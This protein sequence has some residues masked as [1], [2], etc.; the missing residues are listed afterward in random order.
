MIPMR[1]ARSWTVCATALLLASGASAAR[2]EQVPAQQWEREH[3]CGW[4]LSEEGGVRHLASIGQGDGA[5][6][7]SLSDPAF[8]AWSEEDRPMVELILDGDLQN[9]VEAEG[10]ATHGG[11][12]ASA[13][14]GLYLEPDD[15]AAL[16]R[17]TQLQMRRDGQP[18]VDITLAGNLELADLEACVPP[19]DHDH[20]DE[21]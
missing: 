11:E 19:P 9:R 2:A 12:P 5:M 8:A 21:E 13:S 6:M 1:R 16:A 10:W 7:L 15:L 14:F 4:W 18:I 3:E 20:T 17:A